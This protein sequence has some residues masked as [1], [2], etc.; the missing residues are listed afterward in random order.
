MRDSA[1]FKTNAIHPG[2]GLLFATF[3]LG[4]TVLM[5]GSVATLVPGSAIR[6]YTITGLMLV[7][8]LFI[9]RWPYRIAAA[10]LI[11]FC[12]VAALSERA[13]VLKYR[14]RHLPPGTPAQ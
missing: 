4:I 10:A 1:S 9:P 2:K 8:G 5:L 11:A 6:W 3:W 13:E 14:Q 7:A 12:V